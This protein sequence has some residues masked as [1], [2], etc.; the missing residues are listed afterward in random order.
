MTV[1]YVIDHL[2]QSTLVTA[3]I[4]ALTLAFRRTL[5]Q[6][7]YWIWF[8]ASLKFLIPFAALASLG[9]QFEWRQALPPA[10]AEW[11]FAIEAVSQ[12]FSVPLVDSVLPRAMSA[13]GGLRFATVAA[14]FW[15]MGCATVLAVWL[16]RWR[17]VS[18]AVRIGAPITSGRVHDAFTRLGGSSTLPLVASDTS[19]EPGVFGIVRPMLLWPRDIDTRLDDAQ[20]YAILAHELAHVRRRDNLTATVHM[21]VEAIFWFHPLVWWIGARLV[22]ERERAC[23]EEVVRLGSE[24][25][26]YAESILKTCQ[27]Y[28][29][30]PL[31]CVPGVTGS[32]LKKRIERIMAQRPVTVAG[33]WSKTL[34]VSIAVMTLATPV[35]I[36]ALTTPPRSPVADLT[37]ASSKASFEAST[38]KTNRTGGMRVMMRMAPGGIWDASNVTLESMIRLAYRL[39]EFQLTGGPAWIYTDRFDIQA[40]SAQGV[41]P[42]QFGERMQ[43]LLTERFNLKLHRETREL[44][45]YAL[46]FAASD[47]SPGPDLTPATVDCVAFARDRAVTAARGRAPT[48]LPQQ[49]GERP[50]CGTVTGPGRLAGGGVT[51]EQLA[52]SLSQYTGRMVLDRTG[53]NGSFDYELRFAYDPALRGRGPG[54]GLPRPPERASPAEAE[55][56]SIF[57]AVQEQLGLKLDAQRAPVD[58]M[59]I[60]S[61]HQ[62]TVN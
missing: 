43:S 34:L 1:E 55:G 18:A 47:G 3:A 23:D 38:V 4:A 10:P 17:R 45:I 60:D 54:G 27:F 19:L 50:T 53:V 8:A 37:R 52:S 62:P 14:T 13:D 49:P 59:V 51:M 30:S 56:V 20:V 58:V 40:Q 41:A 6:T 15:G 2:W 12:P 42:G 29:E 28:V 35:A 21:F 7:R 36:G 31:S 39:Q 9:A 5:A 57:A 48:L 26:V 16:L 61:V 22:D 11:T 32:D 44:P 24:P 33:A 46:M 25:H